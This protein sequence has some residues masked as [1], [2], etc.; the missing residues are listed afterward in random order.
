[1]SERI[2]H[3]L[4]AAALIAA[5]TAGPGMTDDRVERLVA[6]AIAPAVADGPGGAAV[7][8]L[9]D[10][11]TLFFNFGRADAER[12]VTADALFPLA[13]V[14]KV[15]D[16]TLVA[17]AVLD[18]AMRLD[19]PVA[20]F[21]PELRQGDVGR[22]TVGQLTT[23]TSGLLLRPDYPP[24][25]ARRIPFDE[26]IAMVRSWKAEVEPGTRHTYTHAGFVLLQLA[27]ERRFAMP[28][29]RLVAQRVV[30][31]L[32]LEST[33][34][35]PGDRLPPSLLA[36]A[37]QGYD[38]HGAPFGAPGDAAGFYTIPGS[39]QMFSSARDLAALLA[40][41]LG[42]RPIDPSLQGALR[43]T[44]QGLFR[45]G[46]R[47]MQAMA[48]EVNDLGPT[49]IDKPGGVQN[50]SSY[51]GFTPDGKLG[52]VILANRGERHVYEIGRRLLPALARP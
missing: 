43:L 42:E 51:I 26:L 23:H 14:R 2:G 38:E 33:T 22:I 21:I 48:W 44:Q 34:L 17:R 40:A 29:D 30:T 45:I 52:L 11:R 32:G 15:F 39:G 19:D 1:M 37:V 4:S 20:K 9:I 50:A 41:H 10:G 3:L 18:G 12:P 31:P 28:I 35:P 46:P 27:L 36:R 47:I 16:V 25:P 24:W 6:D 8:V 5:T 13:S 49:V 7:A